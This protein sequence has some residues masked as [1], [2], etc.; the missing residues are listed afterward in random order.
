MKKMK[1]LTLALCLA[2]CAGMLA[3]CCEYILHF[4][5]EAECMTACPGESVKFQV[6]VE[7]QGRNITTQGP[8]QDQWWI[9]LTGADG[10]QIN[11]DPT[12]TGTTAKQTFKKGEQTSA[13]FE[14]QIPEGTPLGSYDLTV[15]FT[16]MSYT[17]ENAVQVVSANA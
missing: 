15:S 14:I 7:N 3:G 13:A 17:F 9:V 6:T 10:T 2:L 4:T 1:W 12:A 16:D 8:L 11:C 5:Y